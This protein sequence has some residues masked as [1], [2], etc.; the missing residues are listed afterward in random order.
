MSLC[1][2]ITNRTLEKTFVTHQYVYFDDVF[3]KDELEKIIELN[4][5]IS[6]KD[7]DVSASDFDAIRVSK[8]THQNPNKN[9][10]WIFDRLNQFIMQVNLDVFNYD[11]TGYEFYQYAEYDEKNAGHYEY[12][13]DIMFN[14]LNLNCGVNNIETR[15]LSMT[16]LLNEPE[17]D[18]EGGEFYVKLGADDEIYK[19]GPVDVTI[20]ED[21]TVSNEETEKDII[22][23]AQ[24]TMTILSSFIDT[25]SLNISDTN[26]LKTLMREL[27][28]EALSKENIE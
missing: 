4:S 25:Q 28:V 9:N 23:Q 2:T 18:F 13:V 14:G 8:I 24:D 20:V 12:H 19:F 6:L 7:G 11:L 17:I 1:Q 27:Y 26:K 21:F 22:D 3:S 5:K 10:Q 15:K 16:L